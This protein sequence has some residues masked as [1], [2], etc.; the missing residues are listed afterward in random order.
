MIGLMILA[1]F[2]FVILIT[3]GLAYV[4]KRKWLK[5]CI[6]VFLPLT[7]YFG[8]FFGHFLQLFVQPIYCH[9]HQKEAGIVIHTTPEEWKATQGK[10]IVI[11][12]LDRFKQYDASLFVRA[13]DF[14]FNYETQKQF[15]GNEYEL[16]FVNKKNPSIALYISDGSGTFNHEHYL[17]YDVDKN[18]ALATLSTY[19]IVYESSFLPF[20]KV[21]YECEARDLSS[22]LDKYIDENYT[23]SIRK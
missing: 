18:I 4:V 23:S 1:F 19:S 16:Y 13:D 10:G 21:G 3:I 22:E 5:C 11:Q 9:I 7:A 14:D 6:I 8:L 17:Y 12:P 2:I 20:P 15:D